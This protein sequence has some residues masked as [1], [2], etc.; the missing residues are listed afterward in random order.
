LNSTTD[1]HV[2]RRL[3][4]WLG[5]CATTQEVSIGVLLCFGM[6]LMYLLS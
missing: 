2:S 5:E 4:L 6:R 3:V 1:L